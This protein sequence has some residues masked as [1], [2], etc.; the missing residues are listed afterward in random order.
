MNQDSNL[1]P[2][3]PSHLVSSNPKLPISA[4]GSTY[5]IDIQFDDF[6]DVPTLFVFHINVVVLSG[7]AIFTFFLT[8][9]SRLTKYNPLKFPKE[10]EKKKKQIAKNRQNCGGK[11]PTNR[12]P[13]F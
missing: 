9:P 12:R 8:Q 5:Q 7:F 6:F 1:R 4:F 3:Y 13:M 2:I 11:E 10:N